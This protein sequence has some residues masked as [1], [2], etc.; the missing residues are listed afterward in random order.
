MLNNFFTVPLSSSSV[1]IFAVDWAVII[2]GIAFDPH[3][4]PIKI[5]AMEIYFPVRCAF[6]S[7][8]RLLLQKFRLPSMIY[9]FTLTPYI[10][11]HYANWIVVVSFSLQLVGGEFDME[12]NFVIQ[13]AQNI[14]HMLELLDHCPPNL[15]V[16]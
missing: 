16:N 9:S 2:V 1:F 13:D 10:F 4:M 8:E 14:K 15:Q 6:R 7:T 3:L 5:K 12:L 11:T